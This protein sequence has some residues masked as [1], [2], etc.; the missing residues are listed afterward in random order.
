MRIRDY[1]QRTNTRRRRFGQS[2][3]G[4]LSFDT[5]P[6]AVA[7]PDDDGELLDQADDELLDEADGIL[8]D[9]T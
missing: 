1:T 3:G 7:P 9:E 5:T 6:T 4:M 8:L 2:D